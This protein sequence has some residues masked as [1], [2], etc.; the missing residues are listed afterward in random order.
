MPARP[1]WPS[2]QTKVSPK[3]RH[4]DAPFPGWPA[5][6]TA[7]H[8][9]LDRGGHHKEKRFRPSQQTTSPTPTYCGGAH[10]SDRCWG[11]IHVCIYIYIYIS[12]SLYLFV[13]ICTHVCIHACMYLRTHVHM[14]PRMYT[15]T[16]YCHKMFPCCYMTTY[17][18]PGARR[19]RG[20]V[21][22]A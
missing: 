1:S 14:H 10:L 22:G 5:S 16:A 18:S 3:S 19:R 7:S 12:L 20:R 11:N 6:S 13:L 9:C 2:A 4:P 17:F 8:V 21:P 15:H